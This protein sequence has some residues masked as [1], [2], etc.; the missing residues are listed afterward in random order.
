[1]RLSQEV[2]RLEWE[3]TA[4]ELGALL[5][6]GELIKTRLPAHNIALRRKV[7]QVMVEFDDDGRPCYRPA[8][9][10]PLV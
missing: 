9:T 6:E 10:L 8:I 3:E 4:G 5:R 1:M 7:N 2:H